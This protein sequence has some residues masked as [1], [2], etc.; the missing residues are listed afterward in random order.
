[1]VLLVNLLALFLSSGLL[2][3]E[4]KV[5]VDAKVLAE[6][7]LF[8]KEVDISGFGLR[9]ETFDKKP[10]PDSVAGPGGVKVPVCVGPLDHW[11]KKYQANA[12]ILPLNA[13]VAGTYLLRV[14]SVN[15][16]R[17]RE[18]FVD[19]GT[20]RLGRVATPTTRD[21]VIT[22]DEFTVK[23][24]QAGTA[25]IRFVSTPDGTEYAYLRRIEWYCVSSPH[26]DRIKPMLVPS[27]RPS[28]VVIPEPD[29]WSRANKAKW[30]KM[31]SSGTWTT[32]PGVPMSDSYAWYGEKKV[33][34]DILRYCRNLYSLPI[35]EAWKIDDYAEFKTRLDYCKRNGIRAILWSRG[36]GGSLHTPGFIR[37]LAQEYSDTVAGIFFL[38][39]NPCLSYVCQRNPRSRFDAA[40]MA[41]T[42]TREFLQYFRGCGIPVIMMK[43]SGGFLVH[44]NYEGGAD[45]VLPENLNVG[46]PWLVWMSNLRGAARQYDKPYGEHVSTWGT[47]FNLDIVESHKPSELEISWYSSFFSDRRCTLFSYE[48]GQPDMFYAR[49]YGAAIK[50]FNAFAK[51]N[52]LRGEAMTPLAV[53]RGYGDGWAN[54]FG[55]GAWQDNSLAPFYLPDLFPWSSADKD[56]ALLDVFGVGLVRFGGGTYGPASE[57]GLWVGT[58]YGQFDFVMSNVTLDV[59]NRYYKTLVFL[60][61][62]RL[63]P[64]EYDIL[65]QFVSG[66]G[67]ILLSVGQLRKPDDSLF[68]PNQLERLTGV[69]INPVKQKTKIT[70][71]LI[72]SLLTPCGSR[73][74][75]SLGYETTSGTARFGKKLFPLSIPELFAWPCRNLRAEI[76]AVDDQKRPLVFRHSLGK[77]EVWLVNA[78]YLIDLAPGMGERIRNSFSAELIRLLADLTPRPVEILPRHDHLQTQVLAYSWGYEVFAVH[79]GGDYLYLPDGKRL[80][81][82]MDLDPIEA[83]ACLNKIQVPFRLQPANLYAGEHQKPQG[84]AKNYELDLGWDTQNPIPL[85]SEQDRLVAYQ[86]VYHYGD[87]PV[88]LREDAVFRGWF[89]PSAQLAV[90]PNTFLVGLKSVTREN[91]KTVLTLEY[92]Q[93][94]SVQIFSVNQKPK[95]INFKPGSHTLVLPQ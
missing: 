76:L 13:P 17:H 12:V 8:A 31:L 1:M 54:V 65:Y 93:P 88:L 29:D 95:Q 42:G 25:E 23:V 68:D 38:E 27:S 79:V 26:L 20:Q 45:I 41:V 32:G 21:G 72:T 43:G 16:L 39:C 60:G 57:A 71:G 49:P 40:Q 30:M 73:G 53:V 78:E 86:K 22:T 24:S 10:F 77:G 36:Q 4:G 5:L 7:G 75:L 58:P 70:G 52:P 56:R 90:K 66:G 74:P 61:Y 47:F 28:R 80:A 44:H 63:T 92:D 82:K 2:S 34:D 81:N 19:Y 62:H 18:F 48:C 33:D 3:A 9:A 50:R 89:F 6:D 55:D 85:L 59:L 15:G 46:G 37:R 87:R 14:T 91:K 67:K 83:V 84:R 94:F 35:V 11:D 64:R 51:R 69:R